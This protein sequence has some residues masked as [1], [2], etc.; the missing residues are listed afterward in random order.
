MN[1][2]VLIVDDSES[3]R[4]MLNFSLESAGYNVLAGKDGKDA[5]RFFDGT[6][7]HLV[8]TD[9]HMPHMDGIS[10]I[11]EVRVLPGYQFIPILFLT[12]ESKG[13]KKEEARQSGA[14]G[15]I[16]KPFLNDK[17]LAVIKKVIR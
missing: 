5:L 1:K 9:L 2:T 17:L 16:V 8:I 12:T 14:T 7:I 10:F 4:E 13:S 3:V 11:K 15:W 6:Q